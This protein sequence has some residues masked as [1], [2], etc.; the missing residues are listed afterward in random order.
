MKKRTLKS[1]VLNKRK[2][3]SLVDGQLLG[4]TSLPITFLCTYISVTC[5]ADTQPKPTDDACN[6][7]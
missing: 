2:V 6:K 4:G 7:K 1:L 3:S 5:T